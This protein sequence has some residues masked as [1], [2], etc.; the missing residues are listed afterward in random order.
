MAS[1][2]T[3]AYCILSWC[4]AGR[5]LGSSEYLC[6]NRKSNKS[7]RSF[8]SQC[9]REYARCTR[10]PLYSSLSTLCATLLVVVDKSN[11]WYACSL[12]SSSLALTPFLC[13]QAIMVAHGPSEMNELERA[14]DGSSPSC[15]CECRR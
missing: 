4:T 2:H 12:L 7:L 15:S 1:R 11:I 8:K 5:I 14:P 3:L 9:D 13:R 6:Q 10:I